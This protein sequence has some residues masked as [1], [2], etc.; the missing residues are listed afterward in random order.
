MATTTVP[1]L[2]DIAMAVADNGDLSGAGNNMHTEALCQR[3][4]VRPAW[5]QYI[6]AVLPHAERGLRN[7]M[8]TTVAEGR[9]VEDDDEKNHTRG[10]D[11]V[12]E[13]SLQK[14]HAA[15]ALSSKD[16]EDNSASSRF[17]VEAAQQAAQ[18]SQ[19]DRTVLPIDALMTSIVSRQQQVPPLLKP[20]KEMGSVPEISTVDVS[21]DR[22]WIARYEKWSAKVYEDTATH[23]D[24]SSKAC[25]P[26]DSLLYL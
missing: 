16:S 14:V 26:H 10:P 25:A 13:L 5:K 8:L 15:I 9:G 21:V 23:T 3:T 1:F 4:A 11:I 18:I 12:C 22:E 24:C 19:L 2:V 20:E 17:V 7:F 6:T